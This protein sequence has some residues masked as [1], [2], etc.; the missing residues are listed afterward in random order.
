MA[1]LAGVFVLVIVGD[2]IV[3]DESPFATAFTVAGWVIWATFVVDFV[4]RLILAGDR[5]AFLGRNWW[6]VVFL[7]LPFLALFRFLMALRLAR[8]GRAVSAIVRGTRSATMKL[9]NRLFAVA[10]VT[11]MVVL[12]GANLLFELGGIRPYSTALHDA[13]LATI[14]GEPVSRDTPVAHVLEIVL[15]LYSVVVFAAV[16]GT[17]GAFFLERRDEQRQDSGSTDV[18]A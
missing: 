16:A 14:T 11:V 18:S 10:A 4:L 8:A 5:R 9:R 17:V 2:T 1:W 7:V 13:A 12:L 6:Q 3:G 15:A